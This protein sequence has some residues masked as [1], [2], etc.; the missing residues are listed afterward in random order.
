[1]PAVV[2]SDPSA[3]VVHQEFCETVKH[4]A[5]PNNVLWHII[6]AETHDKQTSVQINYRKKI[7]CSNSRNMCKEKT[8][9]LWFKT[10]VRV[11]LLLFFSRPL[12]AGLLLATIGFSQLALAYFGPSSFKQMST[13]DA[14]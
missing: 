1:M 14:A 7:V 13:L 9:F 12:I 8:I 11:H 5:N 6:W 2:P 3:S 4:N 10:L